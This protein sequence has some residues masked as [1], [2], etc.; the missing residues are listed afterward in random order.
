MAI[1]GR[2]NSLSSTEETDDF[3]NRQL[4]KPHTIT[5]L[6]LVLISFLYVALYTTATTDYIMNV[7]IGLLAV[8]GLF[9]VHGLLMYQD[10]P[11]IRPHPA[12]WRI[13]RHRYICPR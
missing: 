12:F 2:K 9:L 13:S 8:I 6:I 3:I 1:G 5:I 11:F 4:N 10:G 7:K